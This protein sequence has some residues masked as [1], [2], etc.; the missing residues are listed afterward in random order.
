MTT[1]RDTLRI[2]YSPKEAKPKTPAKLYEE[3]LEARVAELEAETADL[4]ER[5]HEREQELLDALDELD[6]R[7][8]L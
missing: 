3:R 4:T 1:E 5:L 6:R 8:L 2:F 7:G